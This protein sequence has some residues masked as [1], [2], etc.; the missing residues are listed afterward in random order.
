MAQAP[1]VPADDLARLVERPDR[2]TADAVVPVLWRVLDDELAADATQLDVVIRRALQ[3][4][5]L[6]PRS[7]EVT[8]RVMT[9]VTALSHN[10]PKGAREILDSLVPCG[11]TTP[12]LLRSFGALKA[13][14]HRCVAERREIP[15]A[16]LTALVNFART[17]E[18][19]Q[20]RLLTDVLDQFQS[21]HAGWIHQALN[22]LDEYLGRR[23]QRQMASE[24]KDGGSAPLDFARWYDLVQD[25]AAGT[26]QNLDEVI[27]FAREQFG[28]AWR[29]LLAL[30]EQIQSGTMPDRKA[31]KTL[32][33]ELIAS[34]DPE[35]LCAVRVTTETL[36]SWLAS[37]L[38]VFAID[39]REDASPMAE[40][41]KGCL[42]S[43]LQTFTTEAGEVGRCAR[44]LM[45][46]GE[47]PTDENAVRASERW[48]WGSLGIRRS[49][50]PLYRVGLPPLVAQLMNGGHDMQWLEQWFAPMPLAERLAIPPLPDP[51]FS[52]VIDLTWKELGPSRAL[53]NDGVM[54]ELCNPL[55]S[56][57]D[58]LLTSTTLIVLPPMSGCPHSRLVDAATW[59]KE[60][61]TE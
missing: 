4:R 11:T 21:G 38:R 61:T 17:Q 15:D 57:V 41:M 3:T 58:P 33:T 8:A 49:R 25:G 22:V 23:Q 35:A 48:E 43:R 12:S 55:A 27:R 30:L 37:I 5:A 54:T 36:P 26:Q 34:V 31:L 46:I 20:W 13:F 56:D 1:V 60:G 45:L 47:N 2:I 6:D 42:L 18:G 40:T 19:E 50:F 24:S 52:Q 28:T 10:D 14:L 39:A 53:M 32:D 29:S 44:D 9:A 16:T 7:G 51:V 59:N